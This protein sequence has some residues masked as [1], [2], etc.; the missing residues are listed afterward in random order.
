MTQPTPAQL[1]EALTRHASGHGEV[2]EG[3]SALI[4]DGRHWDLVARDS[5]WDGRLTDVLQI[6]AADYDTMRFV[7][8][9]SRPPEV[10]AAVALWSDSA[11]SLED[12]AMVLESGGYDPDPFVSLASAGLLSDALFHHDGTH[13]RVGGEQA[14]TWISDQLNAATAAEIVERTEVMIAETKSQ[15]PLLR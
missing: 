10:A 9:G 8:G 3:I 15:A 1:S 7:A 13:R 11:L 2:P 4:A 12:I 14:G 5:H 6:L